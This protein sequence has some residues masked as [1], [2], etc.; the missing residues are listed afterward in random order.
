MVSQLFYLRENV[1]RSTRLRL[2]RD[3]PRGCPYVGIEDQRQEDLRVAMGRD[4]TIR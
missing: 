1:C 4:S 3:S 2:R